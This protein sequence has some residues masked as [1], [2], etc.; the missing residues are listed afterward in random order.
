MDDLADPPRHTASTKRAL[1]VFFAV[2]VPATAVIETLLITGALRK[3]AL[4]FF[5][6]MWTPG[7][8]AL[9]ATFACDRGARIG[10]RLGPLKYAAIGF[11]LPI[12]YALVYYGVAWSSG[13]GEFSL[14][15]LTAQGDYAADWGGFRRY[16]VL[17]LTSELAI[18]VLFALGEE[19]GWR[20]FLVPELLRT[21]SF[22]QTSLIVGA[23]WAVWHFPLIVAGDYGDP[24]TPLWFRLGCFLVSV[25]A[26]S[27]VL[28]W[29]R[30]RSGSVWPSTLLHGSHNLFIQSL[31]T[32]LT[33]ANARSGYVIGEFGLGLAATTL[34]AACAVLW[35]RSRQATMS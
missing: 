10:W 16:V 33:H 22:L 9:V 26:I 7:I 11:L 14:A 24:S 2:L 29:L 8:A 19:I 12:I 32:P 28:T 4:A 34:L 5:L 17:L 21:R 6:L 1:A 31:F 35:W 27:V 23:L 25:L 13:F 20:G 30:I 15:G 18:G 3:S